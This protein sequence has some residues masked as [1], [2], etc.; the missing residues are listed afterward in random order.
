MLI[1]EVIVLASQKTIACQMDA[2]IS[3][4]VII[5]INQN[6][7]LGVQMIATTR[8]DEKHGSS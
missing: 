1:E 8:V 6:E 5:L 4:F 2:P 3:M 7:R